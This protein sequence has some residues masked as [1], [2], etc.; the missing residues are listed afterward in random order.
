ML[1]CQLTALAGCNQ[2]I[3]CSQF[4][5]ERFIDRSI[6]RRARRRLIDGDLAASQRGRQRGPLQP[7]PMQRLFCILDVTRQLKQG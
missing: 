2:L 7:E 6:A 4:L 1:P 3:D 5:G